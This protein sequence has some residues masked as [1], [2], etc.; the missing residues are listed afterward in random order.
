MSGGHG[1]VIPRA[2]GAA[3]RCGGEGICAECQAERVAV[4]AARPHC[5][6]V[7]GPL[8]EAVKAARYLV[9]QRTR[10]LYEAQDAL[11]NSEKELAHL[12]REL[13]HAQA[14]AWG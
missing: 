1:H 4:D 14:E 12:D 5:T 2:D 7:I 13:A 3:A 9:Q 11:A 10:E 6:P 8:L